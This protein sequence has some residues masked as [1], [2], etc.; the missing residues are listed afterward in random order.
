M[1]STPDPAGRPVVPV[2]DDDDDDD[3]DEL[4]GLDADGPGDA[5]RRRG[6]DERPLRVAALAL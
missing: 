4:D 6:P 3:F 2:L 5:T 1:T